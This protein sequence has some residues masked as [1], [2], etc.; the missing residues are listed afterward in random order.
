MKAKIVQDEFRFDTGV[1]IYE[2]RDGKVFVAKPVK[3]EFEELPPHSASNG[4]TITMSRPAMTAF[5]QALAGQMDDNGIK[6]PSEEKIMGLLE[7]TRAHLGDMRTLLK[8][9]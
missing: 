2:E 1:Y 9:K 4:P 7:A 3:L 8:L 5:L 6:K